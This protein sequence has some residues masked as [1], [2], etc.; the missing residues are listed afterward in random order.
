MDSMRINS[1]L[2]TE[3][4]LALYLPQIRFQIP[5]LPEAN[6][7]EGAVSRRSF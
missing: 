7:E 2:T 5:N 1:S 6:G 4:T 3:V